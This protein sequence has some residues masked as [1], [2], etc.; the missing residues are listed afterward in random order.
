MTRVQH[1]RTGELVEVEDQDQD[2]H[3]ARCADGWLGEDW[4]G[5]LIPCLSCRPHLANR[6]ERLAH[7]LA[8]PTP[9]RRVQ[10]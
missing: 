10:S 9:W 5:R 1:D 8:G 7:I 6:R 4:A 3:D 2:Q